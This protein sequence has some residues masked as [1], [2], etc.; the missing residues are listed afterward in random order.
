MGRTTGEQSG[1]V[2]QEPVET[3]SR[4]QTTTTNS[5]VVNPKQ[6]VELVRL[7]TLGTFGLLYLMY[8]QTIPKDNAQ[9]FQTIVLLMLGFFFGAQYTKATNK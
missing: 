9:M 2:E 8:F 4:V 1:V 5:T 7:V 6:S 3:E